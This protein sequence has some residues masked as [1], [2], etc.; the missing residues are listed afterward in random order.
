[1]TRKD[2]VCVD[3]TCSDENCCASS[4]KPGARCLLAPPPEVSLTTTA[5]LKTIGTAA[6]K[7]EIIAG[8]ME[9][10]GGNSAQ[11]EGI[12]F[13][14][15]ELECMDTVG[16]CSVDSLVEA[17]VTTRTDC[18][19]TGGV[20]T[21]TAT[22]VHGGS[23]VEDVEVKTKAEIPMADDGSICGE[24]A[25]TK[26]KTAAEKSMC[27]NLNQCKGPTVATA[28][29]S[30]CTMASTCAT[31]SDSGRRRLTDYTLTFTAETT[32]DIS[33]TLA[34]QADTLAAS[35]VAN[36]VAASTAAGVEGITAASFT[37]TVDAT[38]VGLRIGLSMSRL[39]TGSVANRC[40]V[41]P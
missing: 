37:V 9:Q 5:K 31:Q 23:A 17:G 4:C 30:D 21:T 25:D 34:E 33:S 11:C 35:F 3:R 2:A 40:R 22:Y 15:T 26:V 8:L 24:A 29:C 39:E 28:D 41:C 18:K 13:A 6:S 32:D 14:G 36:L 1:M 19:T 10:L 38:Q 12:N 20:Y 7:D 27:F 16:T